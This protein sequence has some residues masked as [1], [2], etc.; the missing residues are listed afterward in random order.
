MKTLFLFISILSSIAFTL[1][2]YARIPLDK[3]TLWDYVG[4][5][6]I[7]QYG[8]IGLGLDGYH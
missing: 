1:P 8:T 4:N 3:D 2:A 5:K 7:I 6:D